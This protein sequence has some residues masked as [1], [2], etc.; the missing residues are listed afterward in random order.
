MANNFMIK[1][2]ILFFGY[3]NFFGADAQI[4]KKPDAAS[5]AIQQG[6]YQASTLLT[7]VINKADITLH[8]VNTP[9]T[10]PDFAEM[11]NDEVLSD[12]EEDDDDDELMNANSTNSGDV[13]VSS[14]SKGGKR[15]K[16]KFSAT[17]KPIARRRDD[18]KVA[19]S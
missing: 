19:R 1:L 16:A 12:V 7:S 4:S 11:D 8:D 10:Q 3:L 17:A 5:S 18:P 15:L 2:L 13:A 6:G 14:A 9:D